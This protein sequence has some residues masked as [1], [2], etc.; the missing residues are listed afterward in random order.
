MFAAE[1]LLFE[2]ARPAPEAIPTVFAFPNLYTVGMASLG[3][4]VVWAMLRTNPLLKV[5]RLFTDGSEPIPPNLEL[6]GFSC[7]WELDFTNILGLLETL[8]IPL[9]ACL[10]SEEHP[11]VFGGGPVLTANPEPWAA[12][13]DVVL[14]GD[15][16]DL[17]P[18][19]IQ[20]YAEVR[21]LK[22]G[23]QLER[24]SQVPGV[25]IPSLYHVTYQSP[26]GP[27]A[28]I[29]PMGRA[30]ATITKRTWQG[31]RL[32]ASTV[33]TPNCAWENIYMVEVVRSCPEMCRFCLASYL[34]LPF[35]TPT[36]QGSLLP[37]IAAGLK[38]TSRLGLLGASVTQHPEFPVVLDYIDQPE[39]NHVQLSVSSVR[40]NTLTEHM[41]GILARRGAN[42]VTIA[43]ETGSE[44]LRQVINKKISNQEIEQAAQAVAAGGLKALKLYGMVGLP[45]EE[46]VDL[47]AT[48]TMLKGLKRKGLRI[49]FGCSTFVPKAHTPFQG[50]GVDPK[51][52]QKLTFFARQL[53]KL[54]IDFRPESYGWS[55]MQA[56]ISRGDRRV[57]AVLLNV[58]RTGTSLGSFRRAFKELNGQLPPLA[59]YVHAHWQGPP[60]PWQHL[61]G[62]LA[63]GVL[64]RHLAQAQAQMGIRSPI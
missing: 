31:D 1:T 41:T 25:Y 22:R 9:E 55:V 43:V 50:Y 8:K 37:L 17:I 13:F 39:F 23:E 57:T 18:E 40:A 33:V 46:S 29:E 4:Q 38:V 51:A 63:E 7:S 47:E 6:V 35:R 2:P 52:E 26:T 49:S 16:E 11:L 61:L 14:L 30:P 59:Y 53:P 45:S 15:G 48:L 12:F 54:G 20:T 10:R 64:T 34:T 21:D 44:R 24:L 27:I 56:L 58:H 62:P 5:A 42:S 32:S 3:Y 19:F 60:F 28:T 36:V